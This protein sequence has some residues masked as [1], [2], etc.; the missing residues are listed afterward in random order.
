MA[1]A[2]L[3]ATFALAVANLIAQSGR[4]LSV[5]ITIGELAEIDVVRRRFVVSD[6]SWRPLTDKEPRDV[7]EDI[8]DV[9]FASGWLEI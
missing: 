9:V 3:R 7:D 2:D 1:A 6:D 4:T 5:V 8:A